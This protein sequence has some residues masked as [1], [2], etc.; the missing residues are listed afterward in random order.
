M[1]PDS[2]A[3][4]LI[5]FPVAAQMNGLGDYTY[6]DLQKYLQGK[7]VSVGMGLDSYTRDITGS[8]TP[9]DLPTMMELLYM[10]FTNFSYTPEEFLAAQKQYEGI[11]KTRKQTR[12]MCSAAT[13]PKPS[14]QTPAARQ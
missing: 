12:S 10:T 7:Q 8:T 6:K 9:K 14:T 5:F 13:S 4:S 1:L 3:N 2:Y 11:L